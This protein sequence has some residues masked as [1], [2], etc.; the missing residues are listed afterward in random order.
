MSLVP[1]DGA[2]NTPAPEAASGPFLE[3][4][5]ALRTVHEALQAWQARGP[6]EEHGAS[7]RQTAAAGFLVDRL[8]QAARTAA[9][10]SAP[11]SSAAAAAATN[12]VDA[13]GE[14]PAKRR[15]TAVEGLGIASVPRLQAQVRALQA[16]LRSKEAVL[17][18]QGCA[19][20]TATTGER[21][22]HIFHFNDVCESPLSASLPP[23]PCAKRTAC[24]R[25]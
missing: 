17:R 6:A 11:T 3:S 16:E 9:A 7:D 4:R 12:P 23:S 1:A 14:P 18:R 13:D 21:T 25:T 2:Q 19:T 8:R 20:A 24:A 10:A 5:A 15:A 22:L